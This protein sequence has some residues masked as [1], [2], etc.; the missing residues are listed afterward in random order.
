ML[1]P[2]SPNANISQDYRQLQY[3]RLYNQGI[4]TDTIHDLIQISELFNEL[5]LGA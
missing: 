2:V 1:C 4:D 3:N 5:E